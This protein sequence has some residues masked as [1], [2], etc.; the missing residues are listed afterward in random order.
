MENRRSH[1]QK[2][3]NPAKNCCAT[4]RN[5]RVYRTSHEKPSIPNEHETH[6]LVRAGAGADAGAGATERKQL[7]IGSDA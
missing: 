5:I 3:N 6:P 7:T 2:Q 1:A 4:K